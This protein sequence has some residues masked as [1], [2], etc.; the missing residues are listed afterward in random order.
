[1]SNEHFETLKEFDAFIKT[2]V[3]D[4][5]DSDQ[6]PSDYCF[7]IADGSQYAIYYSHAWDLVEAVRARRTSDL[8]GA[9]LDYAD[10]FPMADDANLD[11]RMTR[12]AYLLTHAALAEEL[13]PA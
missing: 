13:Q 5:A 12:L 2:A 6:D 8:V 9:E 4:F 7:E 3:E 11:T 10:V 1:M